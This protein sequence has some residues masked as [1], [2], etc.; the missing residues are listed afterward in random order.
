MSAS[1]HSTDD[2]LAALREHPD[3]RKAVWRAFLADDQEAAEI[4]KNLLTDD[5][6]KL[7]AR[8]EKAEEERKNDQK[9]VWEAIQEL[10]EAQRQT[11]TTLQTFMESTD[12]RFAALEKK[13]DGIESELNYVS[14]KT[15]QVDA[16]EKLSSYLQSHVKR[17]RR[18][19]REM[20]DWI[21]DT[22]SESGVLTE[23]EGSDLRSVDI[24]AA[25]KDME[26]GKLACVAV[27]VSR[28]VNT[29]DVERAARRAKLF[30]K[31]SRAVVTADPPEF[32]KLFPQLPEKAYGLVVGRHIAEGACREAETKGVL[33]AK[34]HNGHYRE[35]R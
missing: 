27:E 32:R 26:S 16:K 23:R 28:T 19:D 12:K 29:Y 20:I 10:T 5:L 31:A 11:N 3:W 13:V 21:I 24:A 30:L 33:F 2:I 35:G 9:K 17:I 7:P 34:Y 22:A 6:L 18:C 14:G 4:R 15:I 8:F 25:G 1:I